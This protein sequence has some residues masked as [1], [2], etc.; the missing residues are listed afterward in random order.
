MA[1]LHVQRKRKGSLWVWLLMILLIV[2]AAVYIYTHY[3]QL[4]DQVN[5]GKQTSSSLKNLSGPISNT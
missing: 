2:G 3:Y 5:T 1:E 4:K